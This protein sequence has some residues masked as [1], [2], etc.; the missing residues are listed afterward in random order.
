MTRDDIA[1][2]RSWVEQGDTSAGT[3]LIDRHHRTLLRWIATRVESLHT[4]YDISHDVW[5]RVMGGGYLGRGEFAGWLTRVARTEVGRHYRRRTRRPELTPAAR[6]SPTAQ[7]SR[8]EVR[9]ALDEL[10][11]SDQR[12]AMRLRYLHELSAAEVAEQVGAREKTVR[13]RIRLA[14]S[15]L[16][17]RLYLH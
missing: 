12:E 13:S 14:T 17:A 15:K 9:R 7:V 16:R 2:Y 8:L 3:E 10:S 4:A 1:L 11:N 6:T 5:V